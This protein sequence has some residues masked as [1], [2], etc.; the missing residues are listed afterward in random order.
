MRQSKPHECRDWL[1]CRC[2]SGSVDPHPECEIHSG[3]PHIPRCMYCG[4]FMKREVDDEG[5]VRVVRYI[6]RRTYVS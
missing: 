2:Y 5:G 4:R 3:A 1:G 6:V